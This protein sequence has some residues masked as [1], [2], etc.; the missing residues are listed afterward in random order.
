MNKKVKE[1]NNYLLLNI[2]FLHK[3]SFGCDDMMQAI[4][5]K[6]ESTKKK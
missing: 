5:E 2:D 3:F 4:Q 1:G 6:Q